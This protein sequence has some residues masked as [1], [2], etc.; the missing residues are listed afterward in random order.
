METQGS[1]F[2][3][4]Y[5]KYYLWSYLLN[6]KKIGHSM[7]LI[8]CKRLHQEFW[9]LFLHWYMKYNTCL[10]TLYWFFT[11]T[12]YM[13][14][15]FPQTVLMDIMFRVIKNLYPAMSIDIQDR[16][17]YSPWIWASW[18]YYRN[19]CSLRSYA[20]PFRGRDWLC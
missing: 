9:F 18:C 1:P 13:E 11:L 19:S 2:V 7:V 10:A 20:R 3:W 15:G 12:R 17:C 14:H 4:K 5:E 16:L 6:L 8:D